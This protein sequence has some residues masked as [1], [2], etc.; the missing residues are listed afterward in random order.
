[1][2]IETHSPLNNIFNRVNQYLRLLRVLDG[3]RSTSWSLR[4]PHYKSDSDF[5]TLSPPRHQTQGQARVSELSVLPSSTYRVVC[6]VLKR[7]RDR[8]TR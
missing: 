5:R 1:M 8:N 3:S 2:S 6:T 4:S 7:D